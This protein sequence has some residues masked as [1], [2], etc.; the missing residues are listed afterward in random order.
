MSPYRQCGS[1]QNIIHAYLFFTAAHCLLWDYFGTTT[2]TPVNINMVDV[3]LGRFNLDELR[4]DG[5]AKRKIASYVIHPDYALYVNAGSDL[6]VLTL[7]NVVEFNPLIRPI[8]L[9]SDSSKLEDVVSRTGYVV[10][11]G[12]DEV[13]RD[14][15]DQR[16]VRANIVSHETCL[17]A[18]AVYLSVISNNTFCADSRDGLGPCNGDGGNGLILLN[19]ITDSYEL[20]GVVSRTIIKQRSSCDLRK[21]IVYVDVAKYL[22][23]IEQQISM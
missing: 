6:A 12:G 7:N 8:C 4:G 19:N 9:W 5:F 1:L 23:W 13:D 3:V 14:V 21:Y 16:M 22:P 17:S 11:W 18:D 2:Y 15:A 10:G 20:R